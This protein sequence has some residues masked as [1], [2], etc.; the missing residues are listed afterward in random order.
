MTAKKKVLVLLDGSSYLFR[1]YHALPP[2]VTASGQPTGAIYGVINMI[3]RLM[4]NEAPDY[5]AVVFDTKEKTFRHKEYQAY[6]ANRPEMPVELGSQIKPLHDVIRAMGIPLITAPG[7]E[8]DDVIGTLAQ[9]AE[10]ENLSV[11]IS[12]G[13]KDLAQLV[14]DNI[15]LVNTMSDTVLDR[16]GVVEKFGVEPSQ[17]IDYLALMGDTSDNI[18]G[19]PKVGPKTASKW[20][21]EYG[22]IKTLIERAD[23]IKGKIGE[24]LRD[25]LEQLGQSQ[26]LVKLDCAVPLKVSPLDLVVSDRDIPCLKTLFETLEFKRWLK[27]IES[28]PSSKE[29][30][31]PR[32]ATYSTLYSMI[33]VKN[34]IADIEKKGLFCFDLE[35]SSLVTLDAEIIGIALSYEPYKAYYIPV[36]HLESETEQL[37]LRDVLQVLK[38]ILENSEI[39]KIGQNLKY[40]LEVLLNEDIAVKGVA[41]DTMLESY[42]L[43]AAATRHDMDSLANHYLNEETTSYEELCGKGAKQIP[44]AQVSVDKAT[45]YAGEDADVTFRLHQTLN[46]KLIDEPSLLKVYQEI[47]LPLIEVLVSMERKGVK[48][49]ESLLNTQSAE[50][51]E[52]L[53]NLSKQ[54]FDLAGETFNLSSP[55]QLQALLFEKLKLPIISKTPKGQPSTAESVLQELSHDYELPKIIL[56]HRSLSKLKST[57]TDKLPLAVHPQTKRVHTSYHQSGTA[58]GRLSSSDPNL[59]NIPIR[60]IEGKKIRK[61]FIAPPGKKIVAADYSQVE[62]RIMA[63]LS[64]DRGLLKAFEQGEDIHQITASEIFGTALADVSPDQRRSAKAINFGLIYGMSAFGLAKQLDVSREQANGFMETYFERYPGVLTYMESTRKKAA[65]YGYVETIMGRRLYLPEINSKNGLRRK[66]AERAA[67]N[68]PMQGTAAD[69]I[70]A[71]MIQIHHWIETTH[72]N[73]DMIMQVHDELV[74]EVDEHCVDEVVVQIKS[75]M[76]NAYQLAVPLLVEVGVGDNWQEAH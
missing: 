32:E 7:Y 70:K 73:V 9:Q 60:T 65:Q 69:L 27:N 30:L 12:T 33:E 18:P 53:E 25:N 55:K 22:S 47:E 50:L 4:K 66:A 37:K 76:E 52:L 68:A 35:T 34:V 63:H 6:K 2:L 39:K 5:M 43:N 36:G 51:H 16:D 75:Y 49:D 24:S 67:I 28:G 56:E 1:A 17:M 26:W 19:I 23:E 41:F 14:T 71:A 59:Q 46:E 8:A 64:Q 74:F 42:V 20:I 13:D 11:V 57:Y 21:K 72:Q 29:A 58:T 38:P 10:K 44:F 61:A 45:H 3:E 15:T 54:A 40:D 48:I 31:K 62:L